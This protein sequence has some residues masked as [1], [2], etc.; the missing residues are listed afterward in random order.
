MPA[1]RLPMAVACS[2]VKSGFAAVAALVLVACAALVPVAVAALVLVAC[3]VLVL[4][5]GAVLAL[6]FLAAFEI[7]TLSDLLGVLPGEGAAEEAPLEL[8]AL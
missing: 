2:R 1:I 3:A 5:A 8:A 6:A 4:V 7:S